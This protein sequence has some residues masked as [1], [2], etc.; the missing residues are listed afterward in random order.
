MEI[1]AILHQGMSWIQ[2]PQVRVNMV[3]KFKIRELPN[4]LSQYN[5]HTKVGVPG[6]YGS[7]IS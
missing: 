1:R 3:T 4:Q 7:Q 6:S 5:N 2:L